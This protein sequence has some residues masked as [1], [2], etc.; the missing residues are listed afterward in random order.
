MT[1][2]TIVSLLLFVSIQCCVADDRDQLLG[3]WNF[4]SSSKELPSE[5]RGAYLDFVSYS[6]MRASDGSRISE[7]AYNAETIQSGNGLN[8]MLENVSDDGNP[9]CFGKKADKSNLDSLYFLFLVFS[10]DNNL[11]KIYFSRD[12]FQIYERVK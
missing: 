6:K 2:L 8:L 4:Q 9:D 7:I 1:R 12:K 3:R 11:I 10:K 5:C